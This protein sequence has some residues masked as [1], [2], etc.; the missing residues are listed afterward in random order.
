MVQTMICDVQ[1]FVTTMTNRLHL[2]MIGI[3]RK[4]NT[5]F[6]YEYIHVTDKKQKRNGIYPVPLLCCLQEHLFLT[7]FCQVSATNRILK[8]LKKW[9]LANVSFVNLIHHLKLMGLC[10]HYFK[11]KS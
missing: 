5:E 11:Y 1:V 10:L 4:I 9:I 3:R 6:T 2:L 8:P 7:F